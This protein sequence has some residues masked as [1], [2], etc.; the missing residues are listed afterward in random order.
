MTEQIRLPYPVEI[1][2]SR[3]IT[4]GLPNYFADYLQTGGTVSPPR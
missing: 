1:T 4:A 3:L 2:C